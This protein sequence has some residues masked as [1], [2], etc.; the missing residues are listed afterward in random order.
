VRRSG[1]ARTPAARGAI[2]AAAA[3]PRRR[4]D[5][6]PGTVPARGEVDTTERRD[7]MD[8]IATTRRGATREDLSL[9]GDKVRFEDLELTTNAP[10]G[11]PST[12]KR[13]GF[14][15]AKPSEYLVVYRR[16]R[17]RERVSGQGA[18]CFKWPSDTVSIVPT[19]LKEV[20][21]QA[22]QITADN[23]DVRL[24]GSVVYRISDPLKIYKLINF[25]YRQRG[26]AKLARMIADM[27]RSIAKWLVANMGVEDCVRRRKEE[28]ALALKSE[29]SAVVS[30]ECPEGW[31]VDI[32][33]IDI[34]DIFVQDAELFSA[35]QARFKA[36]TQR[37]AE[38]VRLQAKL[39][40]ERRALE[41]E[42]AMAE[43]HHRSELE[44]A[45]MDAERRL[46]VVAL[47]RRHGEAQFEL[48]TARAAHAERLALRAV[49]TAQERER[50][51]AQAELDRE[52]LR[53][54]AR[55]VGAEEDVRALQARLEAES[56]AG[57]ASLQRAFITE[58]L[59][60]VTD[61]LA[62]SMANSRFTV[63]QTA[64]EAGAASPLHFALAQVVDLLQSRVGGGDP[65]R[66][67]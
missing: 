49:E 50:I 59:P 36:E 27:C 58:A 35:L 47:E 4:G 38:L 66:P 63:Y 65:V 24:R 9:A 17:L 41:S 32:I 51:V 43:E 60:S 2:E 25:S 42:R 48:E 53:V 15:A 37:E 40:V 21:F 55:R 12:M 3:A 7:D 64:G 22:N 34:Q 5:R 56:A 1:A 20:I 23:V 18:R 30:A 46:E 31:G 39:E 52:R 8:A 6:R 54:E 26:E 10:D 67:Q 44:R 62:A 13:I 61:A 33:T 14:I 11:D 29:V 28:I 16:G 57:P 19:T 45:R